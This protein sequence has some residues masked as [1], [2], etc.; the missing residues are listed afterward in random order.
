MLGDYL[1]IGRRASEIAASVE[2]GVASGALAPGALLPPMRELA[3]VLG[4][5]PN[6]VAAAYRTLRERGV[7]ETDGRRGSRVRARPA[8]PPPRP[9]RLDVAAGGRESATANPD[10]R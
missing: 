3:G 2:A 8:T 9:L 6:T 10:V 1:I 4:V 7:I 5:N